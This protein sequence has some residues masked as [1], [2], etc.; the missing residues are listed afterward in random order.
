MRLTLYMSTGQETL[1][2]WRVFFWWG[3]GGIELIGYYDSQHNIHRPVFVCTYITNTGTPT[4]YCTDSQL[5][6]YNLRTQSGHTVHLCSSNEKGE[7]FVWNTQLFIKDMCLSLKKY[8]LKPSHLPNPP[9]VLYM[10]MLCSLFIH[11]NGSEAWDCCLGD[12]I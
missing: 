6:R 9:Y 12:Q 4:L 2:C 3:G 10:H 7:Y 5:K 11:S 8:F 1:S